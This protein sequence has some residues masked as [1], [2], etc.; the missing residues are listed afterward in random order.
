MPTLD[1]RKP[2][3]L[4]AT[5]KYAKSFHFF[6]TRDPFD[7][8]KLETGE[9]P[10]GDGVVFQ[11]E[12][13]AEKLNR[14]DR[15]AAVNLGPEIAAI[16]KKLDELEK[17]DAQPIP[18]LYAYVVAAAEEG[19]HKL[20]QAVDLDVQRDSLE[21]KVVQEP[22]KLEFNFAKGAIN[23]YTI[24]YEAIHEVKSVEHELSDGPFKIESAQ[25]T[26]KTA[27][28]WAGTIK[29]KAER[30]G[31]ATLRIKAIGSRAGNPEEEKS[32]EL[33]CAGAEPSIAILPAREPYRLYE[34]EALKVTIAGLES[35][36]LKIE[37]A[38]AADVSPK[39][40]QAPGGVVTITPKKAGT[41]T[42]VA[43][44]ILGG[45]A[46]L[47]ERTQYE[48]VEPK[49]KIVSEEQKFPLGGKLKISLEFENC[50]GVKL[51][52][53]PADR[54]G[55]SVAELKGPDLVELSGK[56]DG[57][58]TLIA[59]AILGKVVKD[60]DKVDFDSQGPQVEVDAYGYSEKGVALPGAFAAQ[61]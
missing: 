45:E 21:L 17:A 53:E 24:T 42:V 16:S 27:D 35:V 55:L 12:V 39:V 26:T 15:R 13:P 8:R 50:D 36:E 43:N 44:G 18:K 4:N 46:T 10:S 14:K 40:L 52:F 32:I 9:K 41:F 33:E 5:A 48:I 58:A 31:S 23:V 22:K 3:T 38:D 57:K 6:L 25:A 1:L 11:K 20:A 19:E 54:I 61:K 7:P 2:G 60:L 49:V 29:V 34:P 30:P 59:S 56:K 28:K 47:E 51:R 37:P